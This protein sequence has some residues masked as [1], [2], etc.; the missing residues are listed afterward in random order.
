MEAK[1]CILCERAL[2]SD[3]N[4]A[5]HI[6]PNAIGGRKKVV[7]LICR[8]CNSDSGSKWDAELARQL[9]S[10]SLLLG[11]TRQRGKVRAQTFQ[12]HSGGSICVNA[13]GTMVLGKPEIQE[14]T[15]GT[16]TRLRIRAATKKQVRQALEELRNR[17]YPQ[18]HGLNMDDLLS[19]AQDQSYYCS[20]PM[21]IPSAFGGTRSGRSLVKS[22]IALVYDAGIDPRQCDLALDY[23]LKDG[24]EACFGYYYDSDKDL[25][26]NRPSRLPFHCVYVRGCSEYSTLVGYIEFYS[27]WRVVLCLSESYTGSDFTHVYAVDP[28][29]GE[30]LDI[31]VKL[32]LSVSDI[33]EA[34]D[35]KL[36]D[37]AAFF[38]AISIVLSMV[39]EIDFARAKDRATQDALETAFAITGAKEGDILTDEQ[40]WDF[41]GIIAAELVPFIVT[42]YADH[43]PEA[44]QPR[45]FNGHQ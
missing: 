43:F 31:E 6:I 42:N 19:T 40:L 34:Y 23:L 35:Y 2:T 18:L 28:I 4:S 45:L 13:D 26:I 1:R 21:K 41:A 14:T 30:E 16:T 32:D 24:K 20:D 11:I 39:R 10:L 17:K 9:E 44:L 27:L 29:K 37:E 33:R 22:A 15:T 12:T 36:Y 5:E 25:I 38:D 3:N 7:G 8:D